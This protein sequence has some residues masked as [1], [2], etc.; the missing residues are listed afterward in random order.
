MSIAS[1]IF[2]IIFAVLQFLI[3]L[4]IVISAWLAISSPIAAS[5]SAISTATGVGGESSIADLVSRT[6]QTA[7]PW[8]TVVFGVLV[9]L[10]AL[11]IA[12]TARFWSSSSRKYQQVRF[13]PASEHHNAVDDWDALTGGSDPT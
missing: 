4:A 9:A 2:R 10:G 11:L 1:L 6:D 7:W 3:G 8:L 13:E 5:A 12:S